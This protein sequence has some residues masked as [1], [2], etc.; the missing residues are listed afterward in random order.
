MNTEKDFKEYL[1]SKQFSQKSID[2]RLMIINQYWKWLDQENMEAGQVGYNDLL[3]FMK[4]CQQKGRSQKTIQHYMVVVR[5]FYEHLLREGQIPINPA[6]DIEVKGVKRKM[7]YHIL[8]PH[9]LHSLYNRYDD[10][11]L[12]GKRNKVM[13]GL[14]VYQGLQT[15]EL[16]MLE[17]SHIKLREGKVDVPGGKRSNGRI[18]KLE[19]HQVMDMYDYV[20]QARPKILEESKQ[21]TNKLLV[22][23][24]G[25]TLVSNFMARLMIQVKEINPSVKN[26]NQIRA[27]VITK[28]LKSYNLREV[29][30]LAG[31]RY[32]S[33][34]E[35]YLQNDMEGLVE[36]IN[37]YHPLN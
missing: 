6:S 33:S 4:H 15:E 21:Q 20:L 25:G 24:S 14:L 31:H 2:S 37:K 36:E 1:K 10:E 35:S 32:I 18:M 5:H 9:E 26:A 16:A 19:A 11:T 22:S 7:L 3:L 12:K 13:L 30:Y 29:Q 17:T 23:P 28:W 8:Q 27:S 34:T